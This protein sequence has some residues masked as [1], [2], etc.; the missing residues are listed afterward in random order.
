VLG[1]GGT[2]ARAAFDWP[3]AGKTGTSQNWRDAWFIGFT[4]EYVTGVWVGNDNDTPMNRV[5][6]G[7]IP[8]QIWRRLMI[9]AHKDLEIRD[10]DW[11]LPD[12]EPMFDEDPR[13]GFYQGLAGEFA[14][15]A[16]RAEPPPLPPPPARPQP[17]DEFDASRPLP[18]EDIPF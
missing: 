8:A 17:R 2:G 18:E 15:A 9:E 1:P 6:G 10:F 3:A 4:P 14:D 7:A 13:N 5:T 16:V 12:P 11:L